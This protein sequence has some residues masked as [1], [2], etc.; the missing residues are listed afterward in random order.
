M[1]NTLLLKIS[2]A[3]AYAAMVAVNVLAN[4]LPIGGVTTGEASARH[5]NLFT[6]AGVT[7][8]IWGLI[9]LL[10]FVYTLRQFGLGRQEGGRERVKLLAAV[11]RYF[12]LTSLANISWIL[13]W[14]H[15]MIGLSVLIMLV[16][17]FFLILIADE[18]KKA[19]LSLTDTLCLRLPFGVYFG[20]I[21]VATIA[22][23]TVY[24]VSLGWNGF[25]IPEA[26]WTVIVLLLGAGIGTVRMLKDRDYFY[27]AAL[28]WAY[29]GIW[30]KHASPG[31]FAGRYPI[32][33]ATAIA[34][35]VVFLG[36]MG[37]IAFQ[38]PSAIK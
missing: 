18:L 16:L 7:F 1:K 12:I 27:G 3:A 13:A 22:N 38:K 10:L 24:L 30:L 35:I 37:S 26:A 32:V 15:G 29:A 14:H 21:T 2:V 36:T 28:A 25:G 33:I 5:A 34:C 11:G 17:L 20:W 23:I 31:G 6:P 8:S 4:A 19:R 9:Y